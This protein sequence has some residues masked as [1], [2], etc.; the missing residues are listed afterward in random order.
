MTRIGD[1]PQSEAEQKLRQRLAVLCALER[2]LAERAGML[3]E[4]Y[5]DLLD[6]RDR[7]ARATESTSNPVA[8]EPDDVLIAR[9]GGRL[10]YAYV[11]SEHP[12]DHAS[13]G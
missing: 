6:A 1:R 2:A 10:A 7:L 3:R 11:R 13:R 9:A 8:A 5:G 4:V 12:P